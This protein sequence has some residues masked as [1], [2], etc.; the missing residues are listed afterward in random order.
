MAP[1]TF[2]PPLRKA[3]RDVGYGT[4]RTWRGRFLALVF[5][6]KADIGKVTFSP[7]EGFNVCYRLDLQHKALVM[8][9]VAAAIAS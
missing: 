2:A 6:F 5:R 9:V 1:L 8:V 3:D 7:Y 4:T